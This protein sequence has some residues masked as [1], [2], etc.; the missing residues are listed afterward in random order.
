MNDS[1]LI[2]ILLVTLA[3]SLQLAYLQVMSRHGARTNYF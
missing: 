2:L 1:L 3:S